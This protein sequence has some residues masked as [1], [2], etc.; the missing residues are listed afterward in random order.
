MLL[1]MIEEGRQQLELDGRFMVAV[2]V[3]RGHKYIEI[4]PVA[5]DKL[6]RPVA[7]FLTAPLRI[8]ANASLH[9]ARERYARKLGGDAAAG[10]W[11]RVAVATEDREALLQV[12]E[13]VTG[14]GATVSVIDPSH[15]RP[16]L[17]VSIPMACRLG[18]LDAEREN[19]VSLVS[20]FL[21]ARYAD[22]F[23]GC[24]WRPP[25][26]LLDCRTSSL[27]LFATHSSAARAELCLKQAL[28]AS[29][30]LAS[31]QCSSCREE[32][33]RWSNVVSA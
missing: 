28:L 9:H 12:R 33:T 18:L 29:A 24:E 6:L 30:R 4:P 8:P 21:F 1:G 26:P 3:R 5:V 2:H 17:R 13:M 20:L 7:G 14:L 22:A 10:G 23:V 15:P 25:A 19:R 16:N 11:A 27:P 31:A 32:T